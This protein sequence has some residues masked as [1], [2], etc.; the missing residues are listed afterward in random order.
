MGRMEY[1]RRREG[2]TNYEKRL[3]L[4]KSRKTRMVVRKSN[5]HIIVQ[6]VDYEPKGDIIKVTVTSQSL[7][8]FGWKPRR[9]TKTAYLTA[10]YAGKLAKSKGI[11]EF[12]LDSGLYDLVKGGV[13]YA[14]LNGAIDSGLKTNY[15]SSILPKGLK[16]DDSITKIVAKINSSN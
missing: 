8:K 4:L 2:K 6:F 5:K 16:D 10:I 11:S 15:D 9:N 13:I 12:I 14:A 3:R 1:R 7:D